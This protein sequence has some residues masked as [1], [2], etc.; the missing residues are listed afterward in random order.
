VRVIHI[1]KYFPP[2]A[3]GMEHYLRDLMVAQDR[4]HVDTAAL[5]HRS[6][7]SLT[8][9][10]EVYRAGEQRLPVTR[11]AVWARFLF[12][13]IS[14]TFPYLLN[15]L[16]RQR[17]PDLLHLH[18]PNVSVFWALFLP[19]A[20][21]LPWVVHWHADVLASAH[22]LGLRLFYRIYR[23][24]ERAILRR[25]KCIIA[26]SPPYL[27][28]SQ[29]LQA[30]LDKCHVLPLGLDPGTL[31]KPAPAPANID[32][33]QP[34]RVLAVGRLTYYKGFEYLIRAAAECDGIEVHL[35]GK[36]AEGARLKALTRELR[37]EKRIRFYGHLPDHA[38]AEKFQAC[39]CLCLPSIERTEAFGMVLLE[40][41]YYGK[42][43]VVS[44]V[45]GSGMEW[46]VDDG[47][48]GLHAPTMN[49]AA[50]AD[51][52]R[53]LHQNRNKLAT[54]GVNG[55]KKF[56]ALF[57]IDKSARLITELYQQTLDNS[58]EL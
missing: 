27:A 17:K 31:P 26:T 40:A 13:P 45:T 15:R 50:L 32:A 56:N 29:P 37:V 54:L 44:R 35:V 46:I 7:L 1:G 47:I 52:L 12:T 25:S 4:Q 8:S 30:F 33:D 11:T 16:I 53:L 51:R 19:G 48:T 5:V 3:G 14:P 9:S 43:T 10:D 28:S 34:L 39:D 49:V 42:A 18:M 23:P 38:L 36:G 57:H 20:R 22:S 58:P 2:Y 6:E 24:F 41:M 55:Q 21:R